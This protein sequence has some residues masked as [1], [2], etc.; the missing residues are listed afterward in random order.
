M[1]K[2]PA[3][4][5]FTLSN[6]QT[7]VGSTTGNQDQINNSS[8]RLLASLGN[9]DGVLPSNSQIKWSD[10]RDKG[11]IRLSNSGTIQNYNIRTGANSGGYGSTYTA[12]KTLVIFNNSGIVGSSSTSNPACRT[13]T[14]NSGDKLQINNTVGAYIVGAG[15]G[16]G[17]GGAAWGMGNTGF[18]GVS[19]GCVPYTT[20]TITNGGAGGNGGNAILVE[21]NP[22]FINNNG[23]IGGGGG[24]GSGSSGAIGFAFPAQ[25]D[26]FYGLGGAGGG[27]GAGSTAG[28]GAGGTT[29]QKYTTG[30]TGLPTN[31]CTGPFPTA[32]L[33]INPVGGTGGTGTLTTGGAGGSA[34]TGGNAGQ[35]GGNLGQGGGGGSS[36]GLAIVG[37]SNVVYSG[38]PLLGGTS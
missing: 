6:L 19:G 7:A 28:G 35:P 32:I 26:G 5:T 15:G 11:V 17:G 27:G 16:G 34:A 25:N 4:G 8:F 30:G 36:A 2:I 20:N 3:T 38:T 9:N 23:T 31:F 18:Y 13:G 22:T 24:G 21:I 29:G 37:Y 1:T 12:G 14:F 33:G 10:F